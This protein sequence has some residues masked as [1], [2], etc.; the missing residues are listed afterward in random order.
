MKQDYPEPFG[1]FRAEPFGW[2]DC[3]ETDDGAMPLFEKQ[4]V[5]RLF[6]ALATARAEIEYEQQLS[7][8][9]QL[10]EVSK[11]G[12]RIALVLEQLLVATKDYASVVP[13][14]DVGHE[15]LEAWSGGE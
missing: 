12:Q 8:R 9:I 5:D 4:D 7:F 14:I 13:L 6:N 2:A 10:E 3:A 1:Y 11:K 15:A